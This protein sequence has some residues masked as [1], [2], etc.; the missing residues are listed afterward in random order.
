MKFNWRTEILPVVCIIAMFVLAIIA[1]PNAPESIPIHWG[2]DGQP[3]N[4]A[5]R[6]FG[7]LGAPLIALGVYAIFFVLPKIDPRKANYEKFWGRYLFMRNL[8]IITLTC[9]N[10]ITFLWVR[11]IVV[12]M[13]M[14]VFMIVGFLFI[15]LGNYMGKLRQTWFVGIRSPW[16]LSS[17]ESWNKTHRLGGWLFVIIGLAMVIAAPFQVKEAFYATGIAGAVMIVVLYIYSYLIW[18][19]DPG[20]GPAGTR[21]S[22]GNKEILK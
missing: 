5:G 9:L 14:A 18:K 19:K 7:L 16:T 3:D 10:I 4:Y 8:V 11:N 1:W 22:G 2:L 13:G 20:A 15:F 17:E 21:I 12:N 6:F